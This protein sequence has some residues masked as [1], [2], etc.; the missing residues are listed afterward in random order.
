M[1]C[2][3][4]VEDIEPVNSAMGNLKVRKYVSGALYLCPY[5]GMFT[6]TH[7]YLELHS[8]TDRDENNVFENC[9]L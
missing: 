9:C 5:C 2:L 4:D 8:I 1:T 3:T 6:S 7:V